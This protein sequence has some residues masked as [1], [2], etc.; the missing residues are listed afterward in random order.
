VRTGKNGMADERAHSVT[1]W[2]ESLKSGDDD[3]A[4]KP[5][6]GYLEAL[7]RVARNRLRGAHRGLTDEEDP[8]L[9]AL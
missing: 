9:S 8:I 3:T 6:K 4:R 7:V 1:A 5:W 2:V